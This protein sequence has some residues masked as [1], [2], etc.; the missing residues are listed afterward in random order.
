GYRF[1]RW[2]LRNRLAATLGVVAVVGVLGGL[3]GALWQAQTAQQ[4]AARAEAVQGF[5]LDMFRAADPYLNQQNPITVNSLISDQAD[6]INSAF[7][8]QEDIRQSLQRTLAEVNERLGNHEAAESIYR[9][10][11]SQYED[12]NGNDFEQGQ[13]YAQLAGQLVAKGDLEKATEAVQQA[14]E[15]TSENRTD[16]AAFEA[17]QQLAKVQVES[18]RHEE[19]IATLESLVEQR[20]TIAALPEGPQLL[21]RVLSDLSERKGYAGDVDAA[22]ELHAQAMPLYRQHFPEQ[23]PDVANAILQLSGIYR[24]S[25]QFAEAVT[26]SYQAA[27]MNREIFGLNHTTVLRSDTTFAVDLA[28]LKCIREAMGVYDGIIE[29]YRSLYGENHELTA[30]ALIN[31]AS[32]KRRAGEYES[33]LEDIDQTLAVYG[34]GDAKTDLLGYAQGIRSSVLFHIGRRDEALVQSGIALETMQA[35]VGE[36][37]PSTM[38]IQSTHGW[39]LFNRGDVA[40]AQPYLEGLVT[41]LTQTFGA[42]A[43]PVKTAAVKWIAAL[44]AL[45]RNEEAQRQI[46]QYSLDQNAIDKAV[47]SGVGQPIPASECQLPS[48]VDVSAF[49]LSG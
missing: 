37:H 2:F 40:A 33:A 19:A 14:V 47:Q 5:L 22:L 39:L 36:A 11:L 4:Q 26:P 23:H 31:Q 46:S 41:Q 38:Q 42:D 25:G 43:P 21:A 27:V 12:S 32:F 45:G 29:R 18:R 13:L 35:A 8:E 1:G 9:D 20:D 44:Q 34:R 16:V 30:S 10:L 24:F 15:L 7:P 48:A 17:R 6:K 3:A 28:Y 49:A